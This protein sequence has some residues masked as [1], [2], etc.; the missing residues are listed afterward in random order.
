MI[1][2][3]QGAEGSLAVDIEPGR[4]GLVDGVSWMS[5]SCELRRPTSGDVEVSKATS[6]SVSAPNLAMCAIALLEVGEV[7]LLIRR[8]H[9]VLSIGARS[10]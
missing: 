4:M 5:S 9:C 6:S 3:P 7:A 8:R 1:R 10:G 2:V